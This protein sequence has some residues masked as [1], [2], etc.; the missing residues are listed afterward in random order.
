MTICPQLVS[1]T[2]LYLSDCF[3]DFLPANFGRLAKLRVL[4]LRENSLTSLPK[5]MASL[6]LIV[7]L[8]RPS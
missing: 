5:S 7:L 8:S 4:E 6:I 2:E 3:L 1:L